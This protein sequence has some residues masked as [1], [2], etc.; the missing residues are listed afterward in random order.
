MA[1]QF[2]I[3]QN[4]HLRAISGN[5]LILDA[6]RDQYLRLDRKQSAWLAEV[7][8][9]SDKSVHISDSARKFLEHAIS[10]GLIELADQNERQNNQCQRR[11]PENALS[12]SAFSTDKPRLA[13]ARQVANAVIASWWVNKQKSFCDTMRIART[14][15]ANTNT[16]SAED[17]DWV[18]SKAQTFHSLTP[19]FFTTKNQ[20]RFRSLVLFKYFSSLGVSVDWVFGVRDSPF[21]AH[22]WVEFQGWLLN[23]HLENASSY[24]PIMSI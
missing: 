4:V 12:I 23:D 16:H 3:A 17:I 18:M 15:K 20:C 19:L 9:A 24:R 7:L 22:C 8:D 5:T 14:W 13:G 6:N 11:A 21:A 2:C 1:K 10:I